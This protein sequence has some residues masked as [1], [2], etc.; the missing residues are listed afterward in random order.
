[1]SIR[2]CL[3]YLCLDC[4]HL[5]YVT[6]YCINNRAPWL[7]I[8]QSSLQ[9]HSPNGSFP[10]EADLLGLHQ[11][12]VIWLFAEDYGR[13]QQRR[14]GRRKRRCSFLHSTGWQWLDSSTKSH[15]FCWGPSPGAPTATP[16]LFR[17]WVVITVVSL[18]SLTLL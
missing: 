6:M 12:V 4:S 11:K 3:K 16:C 18:N 15:S 14:K 9:I 10:W 7:D 8:L 17:S 5:V 13:H 1:M 2:H